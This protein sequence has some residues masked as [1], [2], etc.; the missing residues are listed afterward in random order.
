MPANYHSQSPSTHATLL[1]RLRQTKNGEA[2]TQFVHLY[3]PLVYRYCRL[4]GLQDADSR[5]VTQQVFSIVHRALPRF[6]YD[7]RRGRFRN[8]LGALT[9]H[10]IS[11]HRRMQ[12]RPGRGMGNGWGDELAELCSA[13]P[14]ADWLEELQS[15]LLQHALMTIRPEFEVV[16]WQAFELTW[17]GDE[18]PRAA[19]ERLG[20]PAA[21]IYKT[22]YKVIERLKRELELLTS[23]TPAFQRQI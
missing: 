19:S 21:W 8:W 20:K 6:D 12:D 2:W 4:R 3:T 13:A 15:H 18:N 5:D 14:D 23:D 9:S 10:E 1:L 11:R 22:R 7:P 16:E 17:L